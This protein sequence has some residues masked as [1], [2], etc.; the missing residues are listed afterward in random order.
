M[1]FV[2]SLLALL[3]QNIERPVRAVPDPGVVTTR[4]QITPAGVP[5]I[6]QGR[7]YGVRFG[8]K[9]D[10]LWVLHATHLWKLDWRD[11]RVLTR[12][13]HGAAMPGLQSLALDGE[14]ALFSGRYTAGGKTEIRLMR[15]RVATPELVAGELGENLSGALA[16]GG[17]KALVPLVFNN[18]LAVIDL[19]SGRTLG[20][21]A[22][23]IAP[24][25][26]AINAAGTVAYVT[27]WGGRKPTA[28]DLTAITGYAATADKVVVDARGIASTGS[29][30]RIDLAT[31]QATASIAVELH[32][33]GLAWD[34][35]NARLYVAN[36]NKD[37]VSVIDTR[38]N[39]VVRTIA[40]QPFSQ[41]VAGIAP[42]AIAL[43]PKGDR[44][45]VACGGINAVAVV[46]AASGKVEGLIPTAWYPNSL[47]VSPGGRHLAI[48]S[49][50]GAGSG[51]RDAPNQRA[52]HAIRGA[53]HVVELPD[54]AQL[55][56]FTT[57]VAENNRLPLAGGTRVEAARSTTPHAIPARAGD[58]SLIEHVVYIVKENRTYDQLFGDLGRGNGDPSLVMFG[59]DV[60][61]NQRKLALDYTLLDNFY[62]T[63]GN[64][65]DG[66]QWATQ[67]NEVAYCLWPGYAGRSYPFDGSDPLAYA[68]N[69]FIWDYALARG[70]S[71]RVYGE[72]AGIM[73]TPTAKDR[74]GLLQRWKNGEDLTTQ[75]KT[76]APIAALNKILAPQFPSYTNA[77]PDVVRAQIF[78][79]DLA[80][81]ERSGQMP[82]FSI[83]QLPSDHTYGTSPGTSTPKAMVADNDL[84]VGRI[85]EGLSKS[86]FWP[87]MAIFIV[88]DDA[89][90]GVDH[91]DG[92]RTVALAISPYTKRGTVD[93][94][95]Y[96]H[97]SMLKT[98]EL[99]LG[100]PTMSL[101]D[102][103][104]HDM[105]ASFTDTPD[106]R[107]Y[108]AVTP[109]QDLFEMNP[110]AQALRG[111]Q[112]KAALASAKFKWEVPDAAPSARLNR[113][114]WHDARGWHVPF[115]GTRQAVFAPMTIET[116]DEDEDEK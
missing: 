75:W 56:S 110:P 60:T 5:S 19:K 58:P 112:K 46:N 25:G 30:T 34:E 36:G 78:L 102:L 99:I 91:V 93:S 100:L 113:I 104:A 86:K 73:R 74:I 77:I 61:P 13:L 22:T 29:V 95:F 47:S 18:Q 52:V 35:A 115:P 92:H 106:T 2:F 20:K 62:A 101:F 94:T 55:A 10:E 80:G 89:Q 108:Q 81:W 33:A 26:A 59:A 97:Q 11:N 38:S 23:G 76:T 40:I 79:K 67:A 48:G 85:V 53:A 45:Y 3:S 71:V 16:V 4:Q 1:Y 17:G 44:V 41:S 82:N 27:N 54:A 24:F 8:L 107:P 39:A 42:T 98:I 9:D 87:K 116:D 83:V 21:V 49:L 7:V 88:E 31:M 109:K 111:E 90:N 65:A 68:A 37:S 96:S 57:A 50:L 66:H 70:K 28:K 51:W 32:P 72:Y 69:G 12:T 103:I 84:A 43:S 105:R 63:G 6:F 114:L 15:Q 64:S 14:T